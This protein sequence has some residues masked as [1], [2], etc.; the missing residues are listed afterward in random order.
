[1]NPGKTK[2]SMSERVDLELIMSLE[3]VW[4]KLAKIVKSFDGRY[5]TAFADDFHKTDRAYLESDWTPKGRFLWMLREHGTFMVKLGVHPLLGEGIEAAI[6]LGLG[7]QLYLVDGF[8]VK[9]VSVTEARTL[10]T[11]HEYVCANKSVLHRGL[12]LTKFEVDIHS[13]GFSQPYGEVSFDPRVDLHSISLENLI[14][15]RNIAACETVQASQSLFVPARRITLGGEDLNQM[16][17][18]VRRRSSTL[19]RVA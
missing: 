6:E 16:I 2:R 13:D 17:D 18:D 3:I 8:S 1:M 9:N 19:K 12:L 11:S 15:L 4:E 7:S 10:L 5:L 14:A